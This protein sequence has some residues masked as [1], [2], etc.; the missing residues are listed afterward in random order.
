MPAFAYVGRNSA[1][2]RVQGALEGASASAVADLLLGTGVTPLE[3][4]E[5]KATVKK[6]PGA[7]GG[8][9]TLGG[10]LGPKVEHVD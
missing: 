3:I 4:H 6:E 2:E 7:G 9:I 10:W 5:T 1:G 8:A